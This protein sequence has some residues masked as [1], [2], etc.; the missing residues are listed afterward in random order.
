MQREVPAC[1]PL[2]DRGGHEFPPTPR[3]R[4]ARGGEC[5]GAPPLA[6]KATKHSR[7][8]RCR[9]EQKRSG[10]RP[11]ATV[12]QMRRSCEKQDALPGPKD[13]A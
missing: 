11:A 2:F 4:H 6:E 9:R 10:G 7:Q 1:S 12:S 8:R 5:A 13:C 3:P